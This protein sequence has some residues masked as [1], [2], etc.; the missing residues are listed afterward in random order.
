M[1]HSRITR[2][3]FI[4]GAASAGVVLASTGAASINTPASV[5]TATDQVT[6]GATGIKLT[7]VGI[8]GGT[9]SDTVQ[10]GLGRDKYND[11]IRYAYERGIRYF[12]TAD[13]YGTHTW[14]RDAIK[15]FPREK[16]YI[17]SKISYGPWLG[18]KETTME[19]LDRFRR[20]LNMDYID[21]VLIHCQI[22]PDWDE[23]SKALRDDLEEAKMKKI[24]RAH[25][26]SGH[27]LPATT[28]AA[29]M[30]WVDVNLVRI[31]PQGVDIDNPELT[32]YGDSDESDVPAVVEQ[33]EIMR[34]NGHGIIGMK[35]FA[36]GKFTD[37]EDRRKSLTWVMQSGLVDAVVLGLKSREEI[38]E[39]FMHINNA[40]RN[41]A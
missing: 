36:Q 12:D 22:A 29:S 8:G 20:E 4:K 35:L 34:K 41:Q 38:D 33:M 18:N 26:V 24:I 15:G 27:S 30:D 39:A 31:N 19:T 23:Q 32:V 14:V 13:T 21:T 37:I 6:L 3:Q 1:G 11:L 5:K 10:R 16:L 7:R 40:F 28:K 9:H 17:Q 25:G 2:R